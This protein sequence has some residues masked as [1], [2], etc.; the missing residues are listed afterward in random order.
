MLA[1]P[2]AEI[3]VVLAVVIAIAIAIAT[4][5]LVVAI[6]KLTFGADFVGVRG[7]IGKAGWP[8]GRV[9]VQRTRRM[10]PRYL[11]KPWRPKWVLV[12]GMECC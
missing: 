10:C 7:S 5:E 3:A 6:T 1:P 4:L 9:G 8:K 11:R 12:V 2:V